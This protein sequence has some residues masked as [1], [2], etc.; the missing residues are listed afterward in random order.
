MILNNTPK[1]LIFLSPLSVQRSLEM[2]TI[3]CP[4]SLFNLWV[5]N[6]LVPSVV[7]TSLTPQ[8]AHSYCLWALQRFYLQP[9]LLLW[10]P[11][12][13]WRYFS[14]LAYH[15]S[16]SSHSFSFVFSCCFIWNA[17][18]YQELK[19]SFEFPSIT[20]KVVRIGFQCITKGFWLTDIFNRKCCEICMASSFT[21]KNKKPKNEVFLG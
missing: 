1:I 8:S 17:N 20:Q 13:T 21:G 10:R 2:K 4:C 18:M 11:C 7:C 5:L 9:S 14:L 6:F 12:M 16:A 15:K 19:P 3:I